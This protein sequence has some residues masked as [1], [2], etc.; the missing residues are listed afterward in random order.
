MDENTFLPRKNEETPP[1]EEKEEREKRKEKSEIE[2]QTEENKAFKREDSFFEN[3]EAK[4][5]NEEDVKEL[6]ERWKILHFNSKK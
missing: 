6:L 2:L 3:C 5:L 1:I 4:D